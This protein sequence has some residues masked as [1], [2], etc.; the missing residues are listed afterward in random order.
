MMDPDLKITITEE[1]ASAG[2]RFEFD[3]MIGTGS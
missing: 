2:E 1:G 3:L